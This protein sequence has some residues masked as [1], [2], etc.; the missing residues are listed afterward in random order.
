MQNLCSYTK[1]FI[2]RLN[3]R[4]FRFDPAVIWRMVKVG[5]PASVTAM[6]RT[7]GQL[8]LMWFVVP[9]GTLAVAAHTVGQ[10]VDQLVNNP[11]M[12]FGQAAGILAGQN[13][14]AKEP[15]RAEKTGWTAVAISSSLLVLMSIVLFFWAEWAVRIFTSSAGL[16]DQ[17]SVYVR[18]Q[19]AGYAAF[20]FTM[21]LSQVLNGVGDT[22]PVM[23]F[24]LLG[25]WAVQVPT[26][27]LLSRYTDLGVAGV[28]WGMA[29]GVLARSVI[30]TIYYRTG[31]W[32]T[33]RI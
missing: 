32:K 6:E 26:S 3:L 25:M 7:F 24:T 17:T 8:V 13:L 31:K 23:I 11:I 14:G 30:Y 16:V 28:W 27:F 9:F 21:I 22:L 12:A 1:I 10:R 4:H 5:L 2:V 15:K 29:A 18:I 19:I 20:G 33:R